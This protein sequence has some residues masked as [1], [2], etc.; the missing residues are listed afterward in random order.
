M[1]NTVRCSDTRF[2]PV[3]SLFAVG[4]AVAGLLVVVIGLV[5]LGQFLD[6]M[7]RSLW[8]VRSG[9]PGVVAFAQQGAN[10]RANHRSIYQSYLGLTFA[11]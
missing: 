5:Y 3:E 2:D 11:R 8:R 6:E 7:G 4:L 9:A 10:E 1:K